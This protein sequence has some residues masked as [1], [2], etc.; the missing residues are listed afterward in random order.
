VTYAARVAEAA[1]AVG[2]E[3]SSMQV[4]R[5]AHYVEL[6]YKWNRLSNLIGVAAPAEFITRHIADCLAVLPYVTGNRLADIGSGAGLPGLVIACVN[7][8]LPVDLIEPRGK[9]VRFLQQA[10]IELELS[11]VTVVPQRV[12]DWRPSK[13]PDALVSRALS[14]LHDFVAAT[15]H[16]Q[17]VGV[18]LLAM[19]G[20]MPTPELAALDAPHLTIRTEQLKVP[21]WDSRYVVVADVGAVAT[22]RAAT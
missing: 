10:Q 7:P 13:L 20:R 18:R 6:V 14:G 22:I 1:Q 2:I 21:G 19:K 5:L 3:L 9:R 8:G 4:D 16:L 11:Q 15:R 12:E 17:H